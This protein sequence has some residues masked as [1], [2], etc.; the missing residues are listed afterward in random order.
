MNNMGDMLSAGNRYPGIWAKSKGHFTKVPNSFIDSESRYTGYEKFVWMILK[1]Y[2]MTHKTCWP[3]HD[4]I[5]R[6]SG[7]SIST[8]KKALKGL[9]TKGMI[10]VERKPNHRSNVY[11]VFD[12][13]HSLP[14]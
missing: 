6:K 7:W 14:P 5:S 9:E 2:K 10:A 12:F 11:H 4:T 13:P 3:S 1:K 8:V